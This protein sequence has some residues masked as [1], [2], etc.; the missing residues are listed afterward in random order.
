MSDV[1]AAEW[2]KLRTVRSTYG[3]LAA[4]AAI[5]L[6]GFVIVFAVALDFDR[7]TA[8]ERAHFDAGDARL[9]VIPFTQFCLAALGALVMTSEHGTGMIRPSLVAVPHR[10]TMVAAKAVVVGGVTLVLGQVIAF[11]TF[12]G[13]WLISGGRPAPLWPWATVSDAFGEV[14]SSGLSVALAAL[15]GLGLGLV[16]R[17][18]AGTLVTLGGLLF[19][20][21]PF[22][23]F[24]PAPWDDRVAAVM[25]PNLAPQLAGNADV[26]V[27]SPIGALA[28]MVA[29]VG[30]ALGVGAFALTKRD[31]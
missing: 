10:R 26:G 7:S 13:S 14:A 4:I 28:V 11:A 23:Y 31:A 16:I 17:S 3:L 27:L 18:T 12:L 30:V 21:P 8:D 9:L 15:V 25:L 20:I 1:I 5:M 22:A 6:L 24:L 2:L 29:Y 19:V